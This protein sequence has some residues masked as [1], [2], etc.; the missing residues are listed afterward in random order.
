MAN[1]TLVR[2]DEVFGQWTVLQVA[3]RSKSGDIRWLCECSCGNRSIVT[4]Y[5]LRASRSTKCVYCAGMGHLHDN[6]H[7]HG[8][9]RP[10]NRLYRIWCGINGR[11]TT[12]S[13]TGYKYYGGK[14]VSVCV[15]WAEAY[16]DFKAWAL[17]NGYREDLTIDRI[18]PDGNY[19]PN[20]C[21]WLTRSENTKKMHRQ[22][23]LAVA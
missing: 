19:E 16:K 10:R 17:S 22:R 12:P 14:G 6:R 11:C 20:N 3:S 2:P 5:K 8:E 13:A 1:K 18:N 4:S 21:Q 23:D 15:E 7:T 9:R